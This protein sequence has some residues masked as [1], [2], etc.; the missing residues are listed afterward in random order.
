MFFSAAKVHRQNRARRRSYAFVP[1]RFRKDEQE[2][3]K[4]G[5]SR[6]QAPHF[7]ESQVKGGIGNSKT[8]GNKYG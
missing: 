8:Q 7:I 5:L 1:S 4:Y 2:Q 3:G 6:D